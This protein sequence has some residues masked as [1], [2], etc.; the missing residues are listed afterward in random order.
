MVPWGLNGDLKRITLLGDTRVLFDDRPAT[1]LYAV[2]G[3]VGAIVPHEV[4]GKKTT[5]V[6]VE[7]QGTRSPPATLAVIDSTPALFTLDASGK[8][9]AAMLNDTGCC[10][11]V[12]NPAMRGKPA[13]LY[14]TGEGRIPSGRIA[15]N[16]SVT[17]GG[18]PAQVLYTGNFG[19]LQVNFRV[20]QNAPVGDAI[21][22][23]LR[24]GD[25]QSS[26]DVT[27][28][29]RSA[30]QRVLVLDEDIVIRRRLA[31]I[32]GAAG[33][34][35]STEWN[36]HEEPNAL[37][38]EQPDLVIVDLGMPPQE[39]SDVIRTLRKT[40]PQ[41][42]I[43]TMSQASDPDALRAADL[44]GAQAVLTQPLNAVK[45]RSRVRTL[46]EIRPAVY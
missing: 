29:V 20:P 28:A 21:P 37:A 14:A 46:L 43:M 1:L 25:R 33:Y 36:G 11:S 39:T 23:V 34:L 32:L 41:L 42:R 30:L 27:M 19:S 15:R 13:S 24:V 12:R 38:T 17:V 22:L 44:L 3:R 35:V 9:Q 40:H 8:G 18:V 10:N 26:P 5:Q 6:V 2:R 4:A 7:Y 45:I 16:I 31:R